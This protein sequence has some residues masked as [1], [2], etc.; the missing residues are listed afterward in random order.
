MYEHSGGTDYHHTCGECRHLKHLQVGKRSVYKC[1]R[2]GISGSAAT[3]WRKS[4]VACRNFN[5]K[6]PEKPVSGMGTT[7]VKKT[8][9]IDGQLNIMDFIT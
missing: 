4:Y 2:Y 3:D 6:K 8:D 7:K 9:K 5:K 1:E